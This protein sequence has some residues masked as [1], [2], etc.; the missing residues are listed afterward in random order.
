MSINILLPVVKPA[1]SLTSCL[2]CLNCQGPAPVDSFLEDWLQ[3]GDVDLNGRSQRTALEEL[4]PYLGGDT[5]S[6][7]DDAF[8]ATL[9]HMR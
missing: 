1:R 9:E 3:N 7:A 5:S 2:V 6:G 8:R 4:L